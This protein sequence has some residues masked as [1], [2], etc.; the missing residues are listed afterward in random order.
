MKNYL[1]LFSVVALLILAGCV[2]DPVEI[3]AQNQASAQCPTVMCTM[4]DGRTLYCIK[5]NNVQDT[6]YHYIYYFGTGD[7]NTGTI[8]HSVTAGKSSYNEAIIVMD[9]VSYK[10]VPVK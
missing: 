3:N 9:G 2:R 5:I 6:H 4:P 10:L 7:T 1:L 8:N